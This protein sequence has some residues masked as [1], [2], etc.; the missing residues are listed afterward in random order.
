MAVMRIADPEGL[1]NELEEALRGLL[2]H[3]DEHDHY[4]D[5]PL[6]LDARRAVGPRCTTCGHHEGGPRHMTPEQIASG[7][8][9]SGIHAF[10][11]PREATVQ[12][13]R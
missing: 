8:A 12:P 4:G 10:S 6:I 5:C 13:D 7:R 11:A 3:L 9:P 1:V 2:F